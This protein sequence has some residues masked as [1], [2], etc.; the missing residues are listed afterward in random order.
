MI[1]SQMSKGNSSM[2]NKILQLIT[3]CMFLTTSLYGTSTGPS[4]EPYLSG[5][6]WRHHVDYVL[7]NLDTFQP[8]EVRSGDSIFVEQDSLGNFYQ[9]FV[10]QI[11][12]PYILVT[13]NCDRGGDDPLPGKHEKLLEDPNLY[14]W[15]TQ[16]LD[17]SGHPKL[18]PIPIGLANRK[19]PHGII[20][21]YN[22]SIP[23]AK[24]RM[25]TQWVYGNFALWTNYPVR[26]WVW[27]YFANNNLN[28]MVHL[29]P[30]RDHLVYLQE[31]PH[32]RFVL[33]PRGNGLDTHRT[34]EALLLGSYPIVISSTLDP[35]YEDLPV[36]ILNRWEE[37][38]PALL[39]CKY[40]EFRNRTWNFEKLY[41]AYWFDKLQEVQNFLRDTQ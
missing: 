8:Q 2:K 1:G 25:R 11:Q 23:E 19:Y 15:F 26:S 4:S 35:L 13:A 22:Q 17:R 24:S 40:E 33:S 30:P 18:H 12:F 16:N 34:W 14:A 31:V 29:L 3:G 21:R 7:S 9:N 36:L 37:L 39:M 6:T 27:N 41:F 32:Y 10:P 20:E 38:T 28:G 5:D